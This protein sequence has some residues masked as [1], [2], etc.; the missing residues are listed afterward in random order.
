MLHGEAIQRC[1]NLVNLT[2]YCKLTNTF[3]LDYAKNL[4]TESVDSVINALENLT[5]QNSQVLKL[6]SDV[7]A[8]L[9]EEQ[10]STIT[11]KNWT[12]A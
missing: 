12:L 2:V 5:G 4:T 11:S 8:K 3:L 1:D 6:H 7:K 10:I 9:T